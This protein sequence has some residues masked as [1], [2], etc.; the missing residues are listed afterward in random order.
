[1]HTDVCFFDQVTCILI[2]FFI[3]VCM[4]FVPRSRDKMLLE[5]YMCIYSYLN[6]PYAYS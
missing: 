2:C 6:S 1:M 4:W 5:T 3:H